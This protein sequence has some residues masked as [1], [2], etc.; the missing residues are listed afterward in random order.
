MT[1]VGLKSFLYAGVDKSD[2]RVKAAVEWVRKHYT[3]DENPGMKLSGLFYYFH[4]FAKALDA[5]GHDAIDDEQG[6]KHYWRQDLLD[7]LARRQRD[8]GSW[9]NENQQFME[10][11]A[12]L[13]TSFALLALSHCTPKK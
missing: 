12:N 10:G 7:E 5:F 9:V 1:Y 4:T 8:D 6:Q 11:D 3:L 2:K 13:A